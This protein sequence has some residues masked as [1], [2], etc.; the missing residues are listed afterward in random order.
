MNNWD[1]LVRVWYYAITTLSTIGFGDFLPKSVLEKV[2]AS[3]V[4]MLGV[5]VF[6]YIMG[7]LIEI[8]ISYKQL[9]SNDIEQNDLTKWIALLTRFNGGQK[10]DATLISRIEDFFE[11]YQENNPLISENDQDNCKLMM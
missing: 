1:K 7:Y 3:F 5:S 4:M 2:V 9:Q 8:L 11:F 10:L 6:S